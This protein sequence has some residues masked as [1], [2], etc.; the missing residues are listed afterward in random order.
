MLNSKLPKTQIPYVHL[1]GLPLPKQ[2]QGIWILGSF[3]LGVKS[4]D[5]TPLPFPNF[6]FGLFLDSASEVRTLPLPLPPHNG[7]RE[8]GLQAA[9]TVETAPLPLPPHNGHREF[10]LQAAS[11]VETA[12]LPLVVWCPNFWY[13]VQN[14]LRPKLPICWR[15][16]G[17]VPKLLMPSPKLPKPQ[18]PYFLG[19]GGGVL[20]WDI[21]W[22]FLDMIYKNHCTVSFAIV[23]NL[24]NF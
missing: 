9:S 12:P 6:G 2:T 1:R 5:S 15:W 3:G 14:C 11:T 20:M 10:G 22:E 24:F 8:F 16:G 19:I 18:I 17:G 4:W 13:W 21:W 23:I 7:H